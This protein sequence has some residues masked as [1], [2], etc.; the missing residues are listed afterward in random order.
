MVRIQKFTTINNKQIKLDEHIDIVIVELD[1]I[2]FI[3]VTTI[4]KDKVYYPMAGIEHFE[5]NN[6]IN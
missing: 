4:K 1:N 2:K 3:E 5:I 6:I